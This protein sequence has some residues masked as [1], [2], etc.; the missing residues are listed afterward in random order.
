MEDNAVIILLDKA[1]Y[2]AYSLSHEARFRAN[3]EG[4]GP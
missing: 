1:R 3:E 2:R 4:G